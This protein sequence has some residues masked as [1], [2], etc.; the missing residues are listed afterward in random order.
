MLKQPRPPLL[1]LLS[2]VQLEPQTV[3]SQF[4]VSVSGETKTRSRLTSIT[5]VLEDAQSLSERVLHPVYGT[6]HTLQSNPIRTAYFSGLPSTAPSHR[7]PL[8]CKSVREIPA[9]VCGGGFINGLLHTSQVRKLHVAGTAIT[10]KESSF[11]DR[12]VRAN[13]G[14]FMGI[15]SCE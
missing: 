14:H 7:G 6:R 8:E 5:E 12:G 4:T 2:T 3:A 1:F 13:V 9:C 10:Q 15:H 11:I